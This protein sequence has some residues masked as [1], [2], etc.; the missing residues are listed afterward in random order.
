MNLQFSVVTPSFRQGRFI[1]RTIQSVL[2][3]EVDDMEYMICDGGSE[4]ETI[5]ILNK[6]NSQLRWISEPDQGQSDAIN[7]G[8]AMTTGEII[9][10][11]NSDDIYYPGTFKI[12][13][14]VFENN[15][16]VQVIYGNAN[17]IDEF[18]KIIQPF[19]TEPWNYQRLKETCYVCQPAVFFR[20]TLVEKLGNLDISLNY[21]M[22]YELWLRYGEH[23]KFKYITHT[24]AG[25]RMYSSNK[26][27][28]SRLVAHREITD[29]FQ[30][31]FR[32]IPDSWLLGYALVKVEETT[33]LN[34][35]NDSQ[36]KDFSKALI[37]TTLLEYKTKK[38]FISP[39]I[40]AKMVFW[41]FFPKLSW[42]RR[43]KWPNA[44]SNN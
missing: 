38:K 2:C 6:Y 9:A 30:N 32:R 17:W 21:C 16:D 11:I 7:K 35:F 10:W 25:S 13:K 27:L 18:D 37:Q 40:I 34:R 20:R 39:L 5:S 1:E 15:S 23:H 42:F 28:G 33:N 36:L 31:K 24:F 14:Q 26:T 29:M 19:P 22:D 12:V 41:W 3:Q 43:T 44:E 8:I 4:D